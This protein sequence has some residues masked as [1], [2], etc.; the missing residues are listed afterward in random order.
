VL[1]AANEVAVEAFVN[2]KINFPQITETVR[3]TMEAHQ[4]WRIPGG[5][6]SGGGCLGAK[7]SDKMMK[8]PGIA[9][10]SRSAP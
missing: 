9:C 2:R 1:N 3:R 4:T 5:T 7:R 6:D 10:V 8:A